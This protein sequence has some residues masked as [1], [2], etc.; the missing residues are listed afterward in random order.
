MT[1]IRTFVIGGAV[2]A[3]SMASFISLPMA[4]PTDASPGASEGYRPR[5]RGFQRGEAPLISIALRHKTELNLTGDQVANLE[6]I[7]TQYQYQMTP[8]HEQL[9]ANENDIATILKE[10]PANLVQA[11]LKIQQAEKIRSELRYARVEALENGKSI[12]TSQQ[13]DQLKTLMSTSRGG[14][15]RN[16]HG[17][18]S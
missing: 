3:L 2:L 5:M 16:P 6:K 11:K 14:G 8:F 13:R 10:T 17:Q 1:T 4:A 15:F 18:P 7:R 9:R 12:L